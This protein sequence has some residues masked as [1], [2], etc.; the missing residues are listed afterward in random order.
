MAKKIVM[1][2]VDD[3]DGS[4]GAETA[5]FGLDGVNYEIDLAK[6]NAATLRGALGPYVD[7]GLRVNGR[8]KGSRPRSR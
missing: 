5:S 1:T 4:E 2:V 8:P 7:H 6:A 3:I